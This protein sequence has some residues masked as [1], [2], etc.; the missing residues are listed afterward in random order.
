MTWLV[1]GGAGYIGSH[2]VRRLIA[3]GRPVVV[4]DDLSTGD[5]A[6]VPDDVPL[7]VAADTDREALA[8]LF[9]QYRIAGVAFLAARKSA[10]ESVADP[11]MY[12]GQNLDGMRVLL[13]EMVSAGVTRMV[14]SSSAAVYGVPEEPVVTEETPAAPINPYGETKLMCEWMLRAA[15]AAHGISWIA[16]RFFN[17]VGADDE[18]LADRGGGSLFP[19]VFERVAA[20][21]PAVVTG[22]DFPTRDGTGV[23]DYVHV[24]DIADAHA[25]AIRRL[26]ESA[27][28]EVYNV[29]T[30][31]GYSVLEVIDTLREVADIPVD[32]QT[33]PRRAGDPP[34]VVAAVDK[35]GRDLRWRARHD[36]TDM[37]H[38]AWENWTP[39]EDGAA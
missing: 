39:A 37:V 3:D 34:E 14:L 7:I 25:A 32:V 5:R 30:G 36:V 13:E 2:V 20:G 28:A 26:E 6:R 27:V 4:L 9:R 12:Y 18:V 11:L 33:A 24:A 10:P 1:V 31:R 19:K 23:R 29:G 21:R 17:V 8:T 15:G 38:S 16:L 35:I 22:D